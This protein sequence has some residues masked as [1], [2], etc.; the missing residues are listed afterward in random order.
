MATIPVF[1]AGIVHSI[2]SFFLTTD[3][4]NKRRID[5]RDVFVERQITASLLPNNQFTQSC[6]KRPSDQWIMFQYRNRLNDF[7]NAS[8]YIRSTI[9]SQMS[10]NTFDIIPD[11][12]RQLDICHQRP[13]FLTAGLTA[14]VLP[15]A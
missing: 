9:L 15:A 12:W 6:V 5:I 8:P 2:P 4:Q 11:L 13:S 14:A 10:E 3:R 1:L 7:L